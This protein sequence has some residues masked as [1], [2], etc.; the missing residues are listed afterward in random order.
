VR[1]GGQRHERRQ[2]DLLDA[3][4]SRSPRL[5]LAPGVAAPLRLEE[6]L[7]DASLGNTEVVTPHSAPMLAI[8]ARSGTSSVA[9][10]GPPYSNTHPTLPCVPK[11]A[12]TFRMT[13]L[14]ET[15]GAS[16]PF[17]RIRTT[18]GQV[19]WKAP[20]AIATA[21]SSPPAPMASIPSP[22]PVGVCESD[23][24]RVLPGAPKRSRCTWW[25]MPLPGREKC[26]PKRAA[27]DCRKRWSTAFSKAIWIVLW[28][29]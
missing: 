24:S 17:S 20:P 14:A 3:R 19:R 11:S 12:S 27:H 4:S 28:S 13:S 8:V 10:P 15:Q 1:R 23:P 16:R 7:R 29:T 9:T 21:T 26:M 5:Q 6:L 25:Q 2:V 22:P 18:R